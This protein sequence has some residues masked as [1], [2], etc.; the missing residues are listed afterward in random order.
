MILLSVGINVNLDLV[1]HVLRVFVYTPFPSVQ[2]SQQMTIGPLEAGLGEAVPYALAV[3]FQSLPSWGA[4]L[5]F[6]Q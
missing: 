5:S 2:L 3:V 6:S 4:S 1:S